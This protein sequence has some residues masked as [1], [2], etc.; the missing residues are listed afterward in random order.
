MELAAQAAEGRGSPPGTLSVV[1]DTV[2][3]PADEGPPSITSRVDTLPEAGCRTRLSRLLRH[4]DG[5]VLLVA[6]D[7]SLLAGAHDGDSGYWAPRA[8]ALSALEGGCDGLLAFPG[9]LR[10][11]AGVRSDIARVVNISASTTVGAH[12]R[13]TLIGN[14]E[15]A[16]ALGAD[17]VAVHVNLSSAFEHEMVQ[18]LGTVVNDAGV[19]GMPVLA[20]CYPRRE[21]NDGSD[22]NYESLR[23]DDPSAYTKLVVHAA[24]V[25]ADLGA[26]VI[27]TKFPGSAESVARVVQSCEGV[28][29]VF[30]GGPLR[31]RNLVLAD[32]AAILDGGGSG[33]ALGRNFFARED[34]VTLLA[35]LASALHP[36]ATPSPVRHPQETEE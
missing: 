34:G 18:H 6:L 13:K 12:T 30:A 21:A 10:Q 29:V 14:V 15:A 5:K 32:V 8:A 36:G 24:R 28:P 22:D 20:I 4:G 17:L 11:V 27:K 23:R 26:S 7:D 19:K 9:L 2:T 1:P 31:D 3:A 35:E 25:A 33:V 16:H